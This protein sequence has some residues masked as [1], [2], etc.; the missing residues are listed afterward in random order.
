MQQSLPQGAKVLDVACGTGS[1]S[2]SFAKGGFSVIG[3][4]LSPHML[5]RAR[6]KTEQ[7]LDATFV[8]GDATCLPFP[9]N[10]FDLSSISLGLHHM[11]QDV[12]IKVLQ[13][14][15]RVTKEGS[16]IVIIEYHKPQNPLWDFITYKV[17]KLWESKYFD[18]FVGAGLSWYLDKAYL[19][20]TTKKTFLLGVIQMVTCHNTK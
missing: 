16:D 20:S 15:K 18:H 10:S 3:I 19:Q 8:E 6:K 2:I 4:D 9:D 13:E 5:A 11:P 7:K 14:M 12:A 17:A 1:Q